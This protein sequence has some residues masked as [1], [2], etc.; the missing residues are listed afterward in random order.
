MSK[1]RYC[2]ERNAEKYV[3]F[4]YIIHKKC[5]KEV[6]VDGRVIAALVDMVSDI[7]MICTGEYALVTRIEGVRSGI[8][9]NRKLLYGDIGTV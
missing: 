4:T 8:L 1:K 5:A 2:V 6:T 7:S 3:Y 9:Q